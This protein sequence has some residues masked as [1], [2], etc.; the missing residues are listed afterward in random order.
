MS[1]R[2]P[3]SLVGLGLILSACVSP[4]SATGP[5]PSSPSLPSAAVPSPTTAPTQSGPATTTP[6][7]TALP[8]SPSPSTA[9]AIAWHKLA[10]LPTDASGVTGLVGFRGGYVAVA[11]DGGVWSSSNGSA[12]TMRRLPMPTVPTASG[13]M[14][15]ELQGAAS[16]GRR[17]VIVGGY[18]H[19]PCRAVGEGETG[20]GP[21]CPY[22]P[23]SWVSTDGRSWTSNDPGASPQAPAGY[24][25]GAEFTA[26]WAVPTG[27]WDAAVSW[28][29]GEALHGRDLM[30]SAD[31]LHWT[32]LQPPPGAVIAN[33]DPFPWSHAGAADASGTRLVWQ[34]WMDF[35][36]VV[37]GDGRMV[38]SVSTSPDGM[39]WT[40]A[41]TFPGD[42][43]EVDA[44]LAGTGSPAHWLLAGKTR[45]PDGPDAA[46]VAWQSPD[47]Q[48]WT[49]TQLP[50]NA[51]SSV[52]PWSLVATPTGYVAV[53]ATW[54]GA[55]SD[56]AT[57]LSPDGVAW[58][59]LPRSA[60][61]GADF[62]PR[63]AASGPAG[64]IGIGVSPGGTGSSVW[65]LR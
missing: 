59:V 37:S 49:S 54:D 7:P 5:S 41:T 15:I 63:V 43:A 57:W 31:G 27:G 24:T 38:A 28:W 3:A 39:H 52:T 33:S 60:P 22:R 51:G 46:P 8:A 12:W 58:T 25:Q 29:Q 53:G 47:G 40:A 26:V 1:S 19:G 16:D 14:G 48:T 6:A 55:E 44:G 18:P 56:H 64:V 30:H 32:P 11:R 61:A 2:V 65:Q 50:E 21:A 13:G 20:G 34:N 62:G 4:P 42:G 45:V 23:I 9:A 36:G 35:S 10:V 17:V